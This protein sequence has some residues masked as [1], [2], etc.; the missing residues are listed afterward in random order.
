MVDLAS[1]WSHTVFFTSSKSRIIPSWAGRPGQDAQDVVVT[2][3]PLRA[4][5]ERELMGGAEMKIDAE[6]HLL[7]PAVHLRPA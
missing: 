1:T 7:D 6:Q 4:L 2:V 5:V 3:Q